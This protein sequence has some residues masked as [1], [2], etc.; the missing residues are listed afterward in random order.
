MR[1]TTSR[2]GPPAGIDRATVQPSVPPMRASTAAALPRLDAVQ[3]LSGVVHIHAELPWVTYRGPHPPHR[4]HWATLVIDF[5]PD[6]QIRLSLD[7]ASRK[8]LKRWLRGQLLYAEDV[9]ACVAQAV[10]DAVGV[11]VDVRVKQWKFN[12]VWLTPTARGRPVSG[13]RPPA[14]EPSG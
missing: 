12:G 8:I 4:R 1:T 13:S 7:T 11:A 5:D 14:T 3:V 10:A 2:G 9:G 6:P